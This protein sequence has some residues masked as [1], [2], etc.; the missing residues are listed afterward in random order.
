MQNRFDVWFVYDGQCPLCCLAAESLAIRRSVGQL[1]L[2]DARVSQDHQLLQQ[3]NGLGLD[4]DKG[5]V[6]RILSLD[7]TV[8]STRAYIAS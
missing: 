2:L 6:L 1:H 5:M 4:L 3:I 7:G 8:E